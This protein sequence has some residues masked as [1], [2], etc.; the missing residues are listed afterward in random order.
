MPDDTPCMVEYDTAQAI[1]TAALNRLLHDRVETVTPLQAC[2][3]VLAEDVQAR[4]P[5]PEVDISAMDG[6]AFRLG[7]M[8]QVGAAGLPVR[9]YI[10]AGTRPAPL[11]AGVA[12]E[13]LTGAR[14]PDGADC[15]VARERTA[16]VSGHV[17]LAE[18]VTA[19]PGMNIRWAGEEFCAGQCLLE[20]GTKLDWRHVPLLLD[21]GKTAV[22]V[23]RPLTVSVL[24]NGAEFGC[25]AEDGRTEL[26][27]H[28]L[29][30]M[31][32]S[33][34]VCVTRQVAASDNPDELENALRRCLQQADVVVTTG[35]ISVG[36]TDHVLPVLQRMGASCLF[37]RVRMRPGKP[38]TV[39]Q[40]GKTV[41]FC[42]PGNPGAAALCAQL[43]VVPFLAAMGGCAAQLQPRMPVMGRSQFAYMPPP[44]ATCFLPVAAHN[45]GGETRFSLVPSVG[46]SDIQ[47]LTRACG[48]MRVDAGCAVQAEDWAR[49]IPFSALNA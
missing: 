7:E 20:R 27:T 36:Q 18:G 32:R 33:E 45:A 23:Y 6:Y 5:R 1:L 8:Q 47:C 16:L 28:M 41:V 30:A 17:V 3:R 37:R 10:A 21:Q 39:M 12:S 29:E 48:V 19:K 43:F 38:M 44:D 25:Q 40:V 11:A 22:K 15:V 31:L 13:I 9:G 24:A 2:G 49:M 35:G 42:L 4:S 46:A 34:T 26:N 14:I